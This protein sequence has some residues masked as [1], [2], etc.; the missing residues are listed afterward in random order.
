VTALTP[1]EALNPP[2][3]TALHYRVG[4]HAR[5]VDS[6]LARLA[7]LPALQALT[8]RDRSDPALALLDAWAGV[9]DVLGFYQERIVQEGYLRTATERRSVLELARAI[10]Y[11]LRPGVA[12]STF[13]AFTLETAPGAPAQA[14]IDAGT[15]TQSVP[16]QD[17]KP[18]VF[19][20]LEPL[21]ARAAWNA[22]EVLNQEAVPPHRGGST[23]YLQGQATRLAPGDALLVIGDERRLKPD[24]ENWD[25]RRV[26]RVQVVPPLQ[27]SPDPLAGTTV[28]TL[29]RPL[30]SITPPT[31]PSQKLPRCFA[32][33]TK[34]AL[35]GHAAVDWRTLP[36]SLRASYQGVDKDTDEQANITKQEK[37]PLFSIAGVSEGRKD[38]VYLDASYPK[39]ARGSWV[40]LSTPEYNE[41]YEV[42]ETH[43]AARTM[44]ALAGKSTRLTLSGENLRKRFDERLRDTSVYAESVE[45]G[46]STRPCSGLVDGHTVTLAGVE[47][48]LPAGRWLAFSGHMLADTPANADARKRLLARD[49]LAAVEVAKDARSA[50]FTFT[51][52]ERLVAALQRVSEVVQ[53]A[54]QDTLGDALA[55]H[56][57]LTLATD[58]QHAYLPLTLR[59]NANVAAASHGDSKQMRV[60]PEVLGSGNGSAAFQRFVLRQSPLTYVTA[61]TPSGTQAALDV[62]VDGVRWHEAARSL[63]LGVSDS[64]YLARRADDGTVTLTFGD[65]TH[66]RRL[67]SGQMNVQARYRVGIGSGGN[68]PTEQ[69]S[70]LLDR[71][72]GVKEV[73]NPV[74]AAG[75]ADPEA[76]HDARR[77]A[78]LTVLALERI[79]SLR[80]FEDYAAAFAGVGK[81]QAVWLWNG[82]GRLV[83]LTVV[84]LDGADIDPASA[85]YRNLVAS[86]DSARPAHQ[87]L[88]VERGVVLRFGLTARVRVHAD[89]APEAVLAAVRA[90]LAEAFGFLARAYGQ[91]L[92][93]SEVLGVIQ[94]VSGI[95]RVDLDS[96]RPHPGTPVAG[97]DGR[98]RARGARWQGEHIAPAQLLLLDPTDVV[99]TEL[100]L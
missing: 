4:T 53:L 55:R 34:A 1:V 79:V 23:L 100:S 12:A 67:P 61:P 86:I 32:L 84:G 3:Q 58:L 5:F 52:G 33:R 81:A 21:Q 17:E 6:Q 16:A 7:T 93:G 28:V 49:H 29:D 88:Q 26:A 25:F 82:E 48:A 10:G 64:A 47:P 45:L 75:G 24:N 39:I 22:L 96:L 19:E 85:L 74:P 36:R 98:L 92:A 51:N 56:T 73:L 97:P 42:V 59:I 91:S 18:Q 31:D 46:W 50:T 27:P 72:L 8:T 76:L 71:A 20:T 69:I 40:V 66:G 15:K 90:A 70:M 60:Q 41:V 65:G 38:V 83:H 14:R 30:G 80:D 78:P 95:E 2:G 44:F 99:L 13:L 9:L 11:E 68:L 87:A 37:W 94:R 43:E 54:R 62:R 35:F 57:Q 63:R 77:N 89:Y